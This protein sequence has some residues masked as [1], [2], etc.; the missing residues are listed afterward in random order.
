MVA[1]GALGLVVAAALIGVAHTMTGFALIERAESGMLAV[2][3]AEAFDAASVGIG[4][5]YLAAGVIAAIAFLAWLSRSVDNT[6]SLGGGMPEFTPRWAIGWWFVPIANFWK[7]YQV[8][9]ELDYRMA[10]EKPVDSR[11]VVVWWLF[12]I[13]GSIAAFIFVRLPEPTNLEEL[14]SWFTASLVIDLAQAVGA[15]LAILV[16]RRIQR[17]ADERAASLD[18][19]SDQPLAAEPAV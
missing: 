16:V 8:V 12:W 15:V 6:P 9:Q 7:P 3:E 1:I 11:L 10:A 5:G 2:G 18:A 14:S 13:G 17:R 19:P 4:I